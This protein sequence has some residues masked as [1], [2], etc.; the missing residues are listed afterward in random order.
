MLS[1]RLALVTGS[2]RGIGAAIAQGLA[3][4]GAK[5]VIADMTVDKASATVAAIRA[6]GGEAFGVAMDVTDRGAIDRAAAEIASG[7]GPIGILVNNAGIAPYARFDEPHAA[8]AWQQV[9]TVNLDSVFHV[10]RAFLPALRVTRGV[11]VNVASIAAF[12]SG[13]SS[14]GYTAAKGGVRSLTQYLA[15]ELAP[16]G[17]RVNAIAPGWTLTEM[18]AGEIRDSDD[19]NLYRARTPM[20]RYAR[21]EEMAGPVVFLAS[22]LAS[23]VNGVTLPVDGGHL[24][25]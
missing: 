3:A 9:M 6:A 24:A 20:A 11:I 8:E 13:T 22:E 19:P 2:G 5:V 12:V 25:A 23:Y 21:P 17:I 16:D 14:A 15:R 7:H 18:T 1:G 4:H 10:T